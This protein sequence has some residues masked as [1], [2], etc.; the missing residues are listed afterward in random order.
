M[1]IPFTPDQLNAIRLLITFV[2]VSGLGAHAFYRYKRLARA[3]SPKSWA[4]LL[5]S[6][7]FLLSSSMNF[8]SLLIT[9]ATG[10]YGLT[11][12][13]TV[14]RFTAVLVIT[15]AAFAVTGRRVLGSD[16]NA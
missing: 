12:G 13:V 6:L 1:R 4:F 9:V 5:Y 10:T 14:G 15:Y 2:V 16:A 3:G 11:P 8:I 7:V